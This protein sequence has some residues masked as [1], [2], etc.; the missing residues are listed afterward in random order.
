MMT[1]ETEVK[2]PISSL[3]CSA[4]F[5]LHASEE[6]ITSVN[7]ELYVHPDDG[8]GKQIGRLEAYII[9]VAEM[10]NAR[11][12]PDSDDTDGWVGLVESAACEEMMGFLMEWPH[13]RD[14]I[15]KQIG[16][17]AISCASVHIL[18]AMEIEEQHRGR[19]YGLYLMH[20]YIKCVG[21]INTSDVIICH[22]AP[23]KF[24]T[25]Q[26][27]EKGKTRLRSY[28]SRLGL[29]RLRGSEY[30]AMVSGNLVG[31]DSRQWIVDFPVAQKAK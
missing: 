24:T 21:M 4:S 28:W 13:V 11:W 12:G 1:R 29:K 5:S 2:T 7:G 26:K 22:P 15:L 18:E 23:I 3:D 27:H 8:R 16:E 31:D 9:R 20:Q 6:F 30:F 17:D 14:S 19:N 10:Q 25:R